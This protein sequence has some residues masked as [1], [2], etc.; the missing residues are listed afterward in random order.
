MT[1]KV[2]TAS[3]V[4]SADMLEDILVRPALRWIDLPWYE[5]CPSL[6]AAEAG[7]DNS[8]AYRQ[9]GWINDLGKILTGID[10]VHG[11]DF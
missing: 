4:L 2:F 7:S 10:C 5:A 8:R 6:W 9:L 11:L 1:V 3:V